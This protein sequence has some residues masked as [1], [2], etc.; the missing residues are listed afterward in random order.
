LEKLAADNQ[1][2]DKKNEAERMFNKLYS[3]KL[4]EVAAKKKQSSLAKKDLET[5]KM[6]K[7]ASEDNKE[8][9]TSTKENLTSEYLE[10]CRFLILISFEIS[11]KRVFIGKENGCADCFFF[12]ESN[13][14][15]DQLTTC[16]DKTWMRLF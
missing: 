11:T 8:N 12:S 1:S 3:V 13:T 9:A 16:L 7:T 2:D 14:N 4:Q 10:N 5:K 6:A 15:I